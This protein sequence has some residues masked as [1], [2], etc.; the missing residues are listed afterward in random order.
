M[1]RDDCEGME[2]VLDGLCVNCFR[3]LDEE[4]ENICEDCQS[5]FY[6]HDAHIANP[7]QYMGVLDHEDSLR[8]RRN[9]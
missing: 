8:M 1:R 2:T 6:G 5:M 7:L 4:T 3:P 9:T